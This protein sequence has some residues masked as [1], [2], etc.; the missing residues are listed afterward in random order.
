MDLLTNELS[1]E[2][3][4]GL[5]IRRHEDEEME[6]VEPTIVGETIFEVLLSLRQSN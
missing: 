5:T 2:K 4:S 3:R 1:T 6:C